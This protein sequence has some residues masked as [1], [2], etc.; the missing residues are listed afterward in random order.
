VNHPHEQRPPELGSERLARIFRDTWPA[1]SAAVGVGFIL[2]D[3]LSTGSAHLNGLS[4]IGM[5]FCGVFPVVHYDRARKG[6]E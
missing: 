4:G 6:G 2:L 1:A 5:A 3:F